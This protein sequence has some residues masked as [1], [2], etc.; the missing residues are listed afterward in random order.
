MTKILIF[1]LDGTLL[2]SLADIHYAL[3][4]ALEAHHLPGH[5]LD[6]VRSLVG[7]GLSELVRL[8]LGPEHS[9]ELAPVLAQVRQIYHD[10]PYRFTQPYPGICELLAELKANAAVLA[11][12]TNKMDTVATT[13]VEHFF[14]N[15]FDLIQG[16]TPSLPR[17]PHPDS[18]LGLLKRLAPQAGIDPEDRIKLCQSAVLIGDGETDIHTARNAG[19]RAIGVSWGFRSESELIVAGASQVVPDCQALRQTL[20]QTVK[21]G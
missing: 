20:A 16:E 5:S 13:I 11:V 10:I 18:L 15:V 12:L 8:A 2:D 6:S 7:H 3:N 19:V 1:D 17:K 14:P 9:H 4:T 21:I